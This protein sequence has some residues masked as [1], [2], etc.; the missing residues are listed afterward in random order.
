M[1]EVQEALKNA[2]DLDDY[3]SNLNALNKDNPTDVLQLFN[4]W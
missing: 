1:R 4:N 3:R 2:T